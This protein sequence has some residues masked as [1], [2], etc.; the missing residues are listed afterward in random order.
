MNNS[1]GFTVVELLVSLVVGMLLL[2]SAYQLYLY[3][4][5]NGSTTR[6]R[7]IA[8]SLAYQFMRESSAF[9]TNPC[10]TPT[11]SAPTIPQSANL[12]NATASV[13]IS[14]LASGPTSIS[15]VTSSVT[16]GSPQETVTHSTYV[17]AN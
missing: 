1:K 5:D 17:K 12:P 4:L 11:I 10:T 14:C 9:A 6:M 8:S 2:F 3:V 15:V 7:T 16:F 13:T